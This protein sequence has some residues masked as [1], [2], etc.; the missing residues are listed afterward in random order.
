M[1][2]PYAQ[3]EE[4]AQ[5]R[6]NKYAKLDPFPKIQPALLNS[7][8]ISDYSAKTGM[9]HPFDH[10]KLKSASYEV[11]LLGKV[12][13][14]DGKGKKHSYDIKRGD[15]LEL[16]KNSIAFVTPEPTFR[17]PDY[18]AL[19]FNLKITHVHRGILLGTGPLVDPG[20]EGKLF[21]PLHNLTNN[22]YKCKGGEGLI[23]VEFTK[24]SENRKRWTN[25][26]QDENSTRIGEYVE[27]PA[28]KK[29]QT[30][31]SCI[32]KALKDQD[33]DSI[34]SS[35]PY[36]IERSEESARKAQQSARTTKRFTIGGSIAILVSIITLFVG[37]Y[38]GFQPI[39]SL[40]QDS[41]KY[42]KDEQEEYTNG[43]KQ[44]ARKIEELA[45]EVQ[46]IK[47]TIKELQKDSKK[48]TLE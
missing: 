35:I 4:E 13:Y 28:R 16:A 22:S 31:E 10:Q 9:I 48:K 14:W 33:L 45:N 5:E 11:N 44:Q 23:W 3:S 19:R 40:V 17:L 32:A 7:A 39:L 43:Q 36:V 41:V 1:E 30:P 20:Y 34:P 8:D 15:T 24:I 25:E 29:Y 38:L 2:N 6:F 47:E 37:I 27:F 46:S 21:I 18:I 26:L 12:I 42:V